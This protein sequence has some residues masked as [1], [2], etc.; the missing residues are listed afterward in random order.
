VGIH[1]SIEN[2]I[3]A[4]SFAKETVSLTNGGLLIKSTIHLQSGLSRKDV[5]PRS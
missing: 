3:E 4:S 1:S 2:L 5:S